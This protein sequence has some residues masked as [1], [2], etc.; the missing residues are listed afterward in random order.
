MAKTYWFEIITED[1]DLCGQ[2]FFI[3]MDGTPLDA[4]NKAE[5]LFPC[6]EC[7]LYG[8]VSEDTAEEM[9]LDTY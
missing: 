3:E 1:S 6:E 4:M 8:E 5:E 7:L 9:G 2:E